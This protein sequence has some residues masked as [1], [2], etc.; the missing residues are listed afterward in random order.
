MLLQGGRISSAVCRAWSRTAPQLHLFLAWSHTLP[1][2]VVTLTILTLPHEAARASLWCAMGAATD[3]QLWRAPCWCWA[4]DSLWKRRFLGSYAVAL[5]GLFW[6]DLAVAIF[7]LGWFT[8]KGPYKSQEY[9]VFPTLFPSFH[10]LWGPFL[11]CQPKM[12]ISI[13]QCPSLRKSTSFSAAPGQS[14]GRQDGSS[15]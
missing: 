6:I 8:E 12:K 11:G 5:F 10:D 7:H 15:P 1:A 13:L 4:M 3:Q 9:T 14:H 2:L